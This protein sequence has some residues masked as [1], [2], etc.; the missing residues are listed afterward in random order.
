MQKP[1]IPEQTV[2]R[3]GD[4]E[5]INNKNM[6]ISKRNQNNDADEIRAF[7]KANGFAIL[8]SLVNGKLW[9][10][11]LPLQLDTNAA[12]VEVLCGHVSIANPQ[13]KNFADGAEVLA[14]FSGPHAYISSSWYDHENV[15]TWNYIAV[16]VYGVTRLLHGDEALSAIKKLVDQYEA[17]SARPVSV[18]TMSPD[19]VAQQM[20]GLVCFEIAITDIQAAVT[21]PRRKK[22]C[23]DYTSP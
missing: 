23:R 4:W 20:R 18:E 11:H 21:K 3:N 16:H 5:A 2:G 22:L 15:P 19:Y 17:H 1:E 14:I 9:A 8:T 10:T 13:W 6:Y 7:L 12:G